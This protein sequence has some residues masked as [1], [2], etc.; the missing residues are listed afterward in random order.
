[1]CHLYHETGFLYAAKR[2]DCQLLATKS[3][4]KPARKERIRNEKIKN[5]N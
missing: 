2:E 4:Q 1:M 3:E 5:L